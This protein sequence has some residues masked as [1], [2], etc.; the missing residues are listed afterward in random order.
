MSLVYKL[1]AHL[2]ANC[3]VHTQLQAVERR[4]KY[5]V[6]TGYYRKRRRIN[7]RYV[8]YILKVPTS[9]V[10]SYKVTLMVFA[11][12]PTLVKSGVILEGFGSPLQKLRPSGTVHELIC[13][14]DAYPDCMYLRRLIRTV[15]TTTP[16]PYCRGSP[17]GGTK[18]I[19]SGV[20][21]TFSAHE[22]PHLVAVRMKRMNRLRNGLPRLQ[23]AAA[24]QGGGV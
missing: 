24:G 6:G 9:T 7:T 8:L 12:H 15:C 23:R 1:G 18:T 16:D 10:L 22:Q 2:I 20:S 5:T 13:M 4:Y 19:L 11:S 17:S 14:Y 3:G 21:F